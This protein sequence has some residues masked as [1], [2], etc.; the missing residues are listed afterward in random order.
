MAGGA[1]DRRV[2]AFKIETGHT[3]IEGFDRP[4]ELVVAAGAVAIAELWSELIAVKVL[5]AGEAVLRF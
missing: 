5:V 1:A 2:A 4:F 3:V